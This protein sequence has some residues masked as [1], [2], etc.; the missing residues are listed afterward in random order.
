MAW[1]NLREKLA[2]IEKGGGLRVSFSSLL[3]NAL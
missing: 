3:H 1:L 2:S